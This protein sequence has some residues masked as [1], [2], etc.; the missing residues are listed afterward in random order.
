VEW[1]RRAAAGARRLV[2]KDLWYADD[3]AALAVSAAELQLVLHAVFRWSQDW[4]VKLGLGAGKTAAMFVPA[5]PDA[6]VDPALKPVLMAGTDV[7]Q[8]VDEYRYLGYQLRSDLTD[9]STLQ[10]LRR[11]IVH[12]G[13]RF[14]IYNKVVRSMSVATQRQIVQMMLIGCVS[15]LM[16][17]LPLSADAVKSSLDAPVN[18]VL[19]AVLGAST[20]T[21]VASMLADSG[22]VSMVAQ[23]AQ[24][25]IRLW[26]TLVL[27][28]PWR[29]P[30]ALV[31]RA[32]LDDHEAGERVG[33]SVRTRSWAA[34]MADTAEDVRV[35]TGMASLPQAATLSAVHVA[36]AQVGRRYGYALARALAVRGMTHPGDLPY[37]WPLDHRRPKRQAAGLICYGVFDR[38]PAGRE[39][40][41]AALFGGGIALTPASV[42]GAGFPGSPIGLS[43]QLRTNMS[44]AIIRARQGVSA[45]LSWPFAA[46]RRERRAAAAIV[47]AVADA[48][49]DDAAG[50]ERGVDAPDADA[51]EHPSHPHI[52]RAFQQACEPCPCVLCD[53][54]ALPARPGTCL[55]SAPTS[56]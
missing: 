54:L 17:V 27:L 46:T 12:A 26:Q 33:R 1:P 47:A 43:T 2:I 51:V 3:L 13:N 19:R 30:A 52:A 50:G 11:R 36:S 22:L 14:V 28:E 31:A 45:M 8:W 42:W 49:D 16:A 25:R 41:A 6:P 34:C 56:T 35:A 37:G 48:G 24:H 5:D 20:H 55:W 23:V 32:L 18:H 9:G 44:A 10:V 7:V 53:P 40:R 39:T 21:P 29:S 38:T 4:G 15:Y